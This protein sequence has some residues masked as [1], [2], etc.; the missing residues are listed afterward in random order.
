M[1][2]AIAVRKG[3]FQDLK[4]ALP[5]PIIQKDGLL[6]IAPGGQ[7]IKRAGNFDAQGACHEIDRSRSNPKIKDLT[8]FIL[9]SFCR[10]YP[11]YVL[12]VLS[13]TGLREDFYG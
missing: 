8:P 10:Y 9:H 11:F 6:G 3:F 2:D 12:V 7:V 5:V 4:K 1:A 13:S